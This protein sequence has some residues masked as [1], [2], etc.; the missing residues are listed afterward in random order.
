MSDI[1]AALALSQ[2]CRS[3]RGSLVELRRREQRHLAILLLGRLPT[4]NICRIYHKDLVPRVEH[5]DESNPAGAKR[6]PTLGW[7][8]QFTICAIQVTG[9]W[10]DTA[11]GVV[12]VLMYSVHMYIVL[13]LVMEVLRE[14]SESVVNLAAR[15]TCREHDAAEDSIWGRRP[16]RTCKW[17]L[18][19]RPVRGGEGSQG[20]KEARSSLAARSTPTDNAARVTGVSPSLHQCLV[21]LFENF[22]KPCLVSWPR[23]GQTEP[24]AVTMR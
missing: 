3:C 7:R 20:T 12:I 18:V 9:L 14:H 16:L 23:R 8:W 2:D 10:P 6:A 22:Q 24:P 15:H 13:P 19:Q 21:V 17:S 4:S 5:G 1:T 11:G